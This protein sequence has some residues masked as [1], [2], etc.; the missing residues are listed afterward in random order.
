MDAELVALQVSDRRSE[1]ACSSDVSAEVWR[2]DHKSTSAAMAGQ[3]SRKLPGLSWSPR[4]SQPAWGRAVDTTEAEAEL[5]NRV[6]ELEELLGVGN[7][8]V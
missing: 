8:D 5:L 7:D 3:S 4:L 1:V 6:E 2:Q